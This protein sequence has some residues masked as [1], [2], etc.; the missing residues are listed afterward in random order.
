MTNKMVESTWASMG[1]FLHH[2]DTDI[3]KITRKFEYLHLKI[4]KRKQSVVFN[5]TCI[6][7]Y[8][9]E[10]QRYVLNTPFVTVSF[11][12]R[13]I[14]DQGQLTVSMLPKLIHALS[15]ILSTLSL[16]IY[17]LYIYIYIYIYVY[18][19]T[20]TEWTNHYKTIVL[21]FKKCLILACRAK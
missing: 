17:I 12:S 4:L 9:F 18:T 2:R 7:I 1:Y 14:S 13:Q 20:H 6:N 15:L 10:L 16:Y 3:R 11:L 5:W 19:Y 21:R 8:K